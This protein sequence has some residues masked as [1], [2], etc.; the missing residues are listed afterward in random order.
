MFERLRKFLVAEVPEELS[1]C[2]F[3]CSVPQC[4]QAMWNEC[5]LRNRV[6]YRAVATRPT[7]TRRAPVYSQDVPLAGFCKI[8]SGT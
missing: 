5:T 6:S 2:V 8:K 1:V 3:E 4:T 7:T